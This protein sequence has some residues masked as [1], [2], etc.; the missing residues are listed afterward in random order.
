MKLTITLEVEEEVKVSSK[1]E[2]LNRWERHL[3]NLLDDYF[4]QRQSDSNRMPVLSQVALTR[5]INVNTPAVGGIQVNA[6]SVDSLIVSV[7][8]SAPKLVIEADGIHHSD[9]KQ[10]LRD[11]L[12]NSLLEAA[13]IPMLRLEVEGEK[14]N[15]D[16][17]FATVEIP[18]FDRQMTY[19]TT[20]YLGR[21]ADIDY[22]RTE[23]NK[24]KRA[25][26][27]LDIE[28]SLVEIEWEFPEGWKYVSELGITHTQTK[29]IWKRK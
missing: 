19:T 1:E 7:D 15:L 13:N 5:I 28:L 18:E 21:D 4:Y 23:F 22:S 6:M 25:L 8:K 26:E 20:D 16:V 24:K 12:K 11:K 29:G 10:Q 14:E 27:L 17:L 9:K 3:H 2:V